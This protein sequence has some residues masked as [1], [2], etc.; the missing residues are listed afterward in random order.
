[1]K[2]LMAG[3]LLVIAC[4]LHLSSAWANPG[5]DGDQTFT[6]GATV[7][8]GYGRLNATANAGATSFSVLRSQISLLALPA[9]SC[10]TT[11]CTSALQVGDLLMIYQPQGATIT[12]SDTTSYGDVSNYGSTGLYEF[13]YVSG[14]V[15][16]TGGNQNTEVTLTFSTNAGGTPCT[17]LR[18]TY[19]L[20]TDAGVAPPMIIRVPQYR[21]LTVNAGAS[22]VAA[23]WAWSTGSTGLGGVLVVDVRDSGTGSGTTIVNGE[24]SATGRG[25]RGGTDTSSS[26]DTDNN[27]SNGYRNTVAGSQPNA[28]KGESIVGNVA[29]YDNQNGRFGRGAP[30][31]GG[32]GGAGHN[33]AGG[34]GSNAGSSAPGNSNSYGGSLGI[35]DLT[36]SADPGNGN[37]YFQAWCLDP[38]IGNG[39]TSCI[40][41]NLGSGGGRGGYTWAALYAPSPFITAPGNNAWGT[42]GENRRYNFGGLGGRPMD[43]A[44]TS[45][46]RNQ[47]YPRLFFGGG[48]GAGDA[49]NSGGT[50]AGWGGAGCAAPNIGVP[51]NDGGNGGGLVFL[52]TSRVQGSGSIQ[53]NGAA[54]ELSCGVSGEAPGGGGG[55]GTVVITTGAPGAVLPG[56]LSVAAQGGEGGD[57]TNADTNRGVNCA[58]AGTDCEAQGGGGG[59]G[60]GVIMAPAG[61]SKTVAGGDYGITFATTMEGIISG[62]TSGRFYPNGATTGVTGISTTPPPRTGDSSPFNCLEG[63]GYTTPVNLAYF[64]AI[65]SDSNVQIR[66]A[67]ASEVGN[68]GF[69]I[70]ANVPL[71]ADQTEVFVPSHSGYSDVPQ[72]YQVSIPPSGA[73]SLY[74]V[75]I[76]LL[77]GER[78]HGPFQIGKAYGEPPA[79]DG[80]DWQVSR[81]QRDN[82]QASTRRSQSLAAKLAVRETGMYRVSHAQLLASGVNLIGIPSREIAVLSQRGPVS[83]LV[84]GPDLFASDSSIVFFAEEH[85][86]LWSRDHFYLI[87][88]AAASAV[89]MQRMD[90]TASTPA[91]STQRVVLRHAA[92]VGY[93]PAAPLGDPWYARRLLAQGSAVSTTIELNGA[94]P[95]NPAAELEVLLWG[96]LAYDGAE[97]DHSVRVLIN[98]QEI[99]TARWSGVSTEAI[100]VPVELLSLPLSVTI[101]VSGDTPYPLDI[102]YLESVQLSYEANATASNGVFLGTKLGPALSETVFSDA[103]GD[104]STFIHGAVTVTGVSGSQT[105]AFRIDHGNATEIAV[106][107]S[108]SDATL[109]AESILSDSQVWVGDESALRSATLLAMPADDSLLEGNA[110]WLAISHGMFLP[111]VDALVAQRQAEGLSTKV[112]DVERI[113]ARYSAGNPDPAAIA[114]YIADSRRALGV[115]YVVLVGGDTVDAPGYLNSGS[116]SFI[117]TPYVATNRFVQFAPADAALGDVDGDGIPDLAVGRI[118]ARTL[119]EATEMI[120][121][122]LAH[123]QQPVHDQIMLVAGPD[124]GQ[125][126]FAADA[127]LLDQGL[128]ASWQRSYAYQSELGLA[129]ARLALVQGF[130]SGKS[131]LSY[132]GHSG[133]TRWTFD[134]LFTTSQVLGT[135]PDATLRLQDSDNY[136]IVLQFACWTTY[137]VSAQQNSMAQVLLSAPGRGASAV[138]GASVLMEQSSHQA[139]ATAIRPHLQ[140]GRRIGDALQAAKRS[141]ALDPALAYKR[142]TQLAVVILGDPAQPIR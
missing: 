23:P 63:P 104:A 71:Q 35:P 61:A 111:A 98:G 19:T 127:G 120:R 66:F 18:N 93:D 57:Q 70:E 126:S 44:A 72:S 102:V 89:P 103:F 48:G 137:F 108:G 142:E 31:N 100:R 77:N 114:R 131:L 110:E 81:Q 49:N 45:T 28:E 55:G 20:S 43:A 58:G 37:G 4:F 74:L 113:Y 36:G 47:A 118:P 34:G 128:P 125:I 5:E 33:G 85:S 24:L 64:H 68:R 10:P 65:E 132:V 101:E 75:D 139:M 51:P 94:A 13:V 1:M 41:H 88:H 97:P 129:D 40:S 116:V 115:R 136:P 141:I 38:V 140:V 17:G 82:Y 76:D 106:T 69:R 90:R 2:I 105:R 134:P 122:I 32:G 130:N 46:Q 8:N 11:T 62:M 87:K 29:R 79:L 121:K 117:P 39:T 133:P 83:R 124:D 6:T 52:I 56:T 119:A 84:E 50:G 16:S 22:L 54:G 92:Q 30:A 96:G 91:A 99:A 25:F 15:P 12:N 3:R 53:A 60:G 135:H 107:R 59:G 112:V 26:G 86:S 9:G 14:S 109:Y 42:S 73:L 123:A 7:V 78:R 21:N 80:Y 27:D 67:M 138:V 95:S